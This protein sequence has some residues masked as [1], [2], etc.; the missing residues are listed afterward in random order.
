MDKSC[1]NDTGY[2]TYLILNAI[3]ISRTFMC[4]S[5]GNQ[6]IFNTFQLCD[7]IKRLQNA[8]HTQIYTY[9]YIFYIYM[10]RTHF[11]HTAVSILTLQWVR[12]GTVTRHHWMSL[13]WHLASLSS[14]FLRDRWIIWQHTRIKY[15]PI[16]E[17]SALS[18]PT[19]IY[20][21]FCRA[22]KRTAT[23]VEIDIGRYL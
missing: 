7:T 18:N 20:P 13:N 4:N 16:W 2:T 23:T 15:K 6:V 11:P 5:D 19:V 17:R 21:I 22:E 3:C 10:W 12:E 8:V 14:I 9:I 1:H